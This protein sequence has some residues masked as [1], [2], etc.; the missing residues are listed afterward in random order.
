MKVAKAAF[1]KALDEMATFKK[2]RKKMS[3]SAAAEAYKRVHALKVKAKDTLKEAQSQDAILSAKCS[4]SSKEFAAANK[5]MQEAAAKLDKELALE[6]EVKQ[7][8]AKLPPVLQQSPKIN[9]KPKVAEK[10]HPYQV[11]DNFLTKT[12]SD[13]AAFKKK[14]YDDALNKLRTEKAKADSD[15]H[16]KMEKARKLKELKDEVLK[17]MR[18]KQAL[19]DVMQELGLGTVDQQVAE[20]KA[21]KA[22]LAQ[23]KK[24][25]ADAQKKLDSTKD[26]LNKSFFSEKES[27]ISTNGELLKA[28]AMALISDND[29][30]SVAQKA[31]NEAEALSTWGDG[32]AF[33]V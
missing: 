31:L 21:R 28:D 24:A 3:G 26:Q 30:D 25:E 32:H 9:P 22:Q 17:Q 33:S 18:E 1:E 6:N 8:L 15:A 10:I 16:E 20:G 29:A 4:I 12:A 7:K 2:E 13:R 27:A 23:M 11:L 19:S 5:Q 14:M